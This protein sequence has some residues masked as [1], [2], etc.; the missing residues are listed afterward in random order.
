MQQSW[1]KPPVERGGL[2]GGLGG[3]GGRPTNA[4]TLW[5]DG[6]YLLMFP[7]SMPVG[8]P[9]VTTGAPAGLGVIGTG[10][11]S[12]LHGAG[13]L[14]LGTLSGFRLTA[15]F[16]RPQDHRLGLEV[17]GMYVSPGSNDFYGRSADNGIPVLTRPFF[18][19]ATGQNASLIVSFPNF[20]AGS[21][22]SRATS[23]FWGIEANAVANIYRS[24]PDA[25]IS[26]ALNGVVGFR[27]AG[28]QEGLTV[29]QQSQLLPGNTAPYAGITVAAPTSLLV[30]DRFHT[31][32]N[33][34]GGQL[35]LQWQAS[36]GRW[37]TSVTAKVGLGLMNQE[38]RI[39]GMS[40]SSNPTAAVGGSTLAL[41][42][43]YAN[44]SNIGTYRDDRFGVLTDVNGTVGYNVTK[45]F[46]VTA[47][48][49]FV[50]MNTVARPTN[51]FSGAVDPSLVPTS[52]TFGATPVGTPPFAIKQTDY[53]LHGLNFGFVARY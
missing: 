12:P 50:H 26:C 18:N 29:S 42:G 17:T 2:L 32:N 19:T 4:P 46:T 40:G 35:G 7:K 37:Y 52:G 53:W 48:Y 41:G 24:S 11:S 30:E 25:L 49:N 22:L 13:N 9:L 31:N 1:E 16:F 8:F 43:L 51:Q 39:E 34:Y 36:V 38:V 44:A 45:F 20:S 10:T 27:Y 6:Q 3:L 5:F 33:F 28:L 14:S 15:G 21:I 47:G 23:E